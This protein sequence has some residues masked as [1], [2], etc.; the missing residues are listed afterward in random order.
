MKKLLYAIVGLPFIC[1]ALNNNNPDTIQTTHIEE[2][3]IAVEDTPI[4]DS[5]IEERSIGI[6]NFDTDVDTVVCDTLV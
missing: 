1:V 4:I 5:I 6:V 3:S 2:D